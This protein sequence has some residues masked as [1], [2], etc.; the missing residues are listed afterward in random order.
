MSQNDPQSATALR[1]LGARPTLNALRLVNTA[2]L[3]DG[4]LCWVGERA[5]YYVLRR[6]TEPPENALDSN[7]EVVAPA[8]GP[9]CWFRTYALAPTA[10]LL[11]APN[12]IA[13]GSAEDVQLG[14]PGEWVF[15]ELRVFPST[16]LTGWKASENGLMVYTAD[17]P[18]IV[19]TKIQVALGSR[20][21]RFNVAVA[22]GVRR[23]ESAE[24]EPQ[25]VFGALATAPSDRDFASLTAVGFADAT[26]G[27]ELRVGF[28]NIDEPHKPVIRLGA[29]AVSLVRIA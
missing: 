8:S 28:Q 18:A 17:E 15:P 24:F 7:G 10:A 2:P 5:V 14:Q 11:F 27:T 21:D 12:V 22:L 19:E 16:T 1:V 29:L 9:G 3:P 26:L 6:N 20:S 25:A 13:R 23:P 4:A